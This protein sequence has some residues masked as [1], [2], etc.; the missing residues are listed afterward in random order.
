MGGLGLTAAVWGYLGPPGDVIWVL[1]C[2]LKL[3][4]FSW[5]ILDLSGPI[6]SVWTYLE[7]FGN[8]WNS[9]GL[10]GTLVL[11]RAIWHTP[12]LCGAI[13]GCLCPAELSGVLLAYGA[14]WG[15]V[16]DYLG[17]SGAIWSKL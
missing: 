2:Y 8:L 13:L 10:A 3:F 9:L 17:L 6:W 16:W 7:L 1:W 15:Y 12:G 14:S 11:A 5:G 4:E